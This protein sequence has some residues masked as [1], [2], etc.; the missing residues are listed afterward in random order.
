M[1]TDPCL[2][3]TSQYTSSEDPNSQ[4]ELPKRERKCETNFFDHKNI[5]K[6]SIKLT[7]GQNLLVYRTV[8][9]FRRVDLLD[10]KK[11]EGL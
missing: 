8:F 9:N 11:S 4:I 7:K 6:C 5:L 3:V 2:P 10:L 1:K